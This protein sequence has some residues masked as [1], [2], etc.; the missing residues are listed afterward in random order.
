MSGAQTRRGKDED[1][2]NK[3]AAVTGGARGI[4]AAIHALEVGH[5]V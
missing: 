3:V 5:G 4:G 1:M 2:M